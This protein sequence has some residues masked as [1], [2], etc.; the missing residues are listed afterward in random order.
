M[1]YFKKI[2][3][4]VIVPLFYFLAI[5]SAF[6]ADENEQSDR[7]LSP[8]YKKPLIPEEERALHHTAFNDPSASEEQKAKAA[9]LLA[10]I[11]FNQGAALDRGCALYEF[12]E[13]TRSPVLPEDYKAMAYFYM[14]QI[15]FDGIGIS[16]S[17]PAQEQ[18][19]KYFKLALLSPALPE[20]LRALT[21]SRIAEIGRRL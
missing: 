7:G 16:P 12:D 17:C 8:L 4:S 1:N 21:T 6:S 18:A 10:E 15:F 14:G 19:K 5:P 2:S 9:Y 11:S 13:A 20:N 3:L